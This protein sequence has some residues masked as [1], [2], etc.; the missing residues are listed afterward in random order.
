MAATDPAFADAQVILGRV[1]QLA[2][3]TTDAAAL[4]AAAGDRPDAK[5][6]LATLAFEAGRFTDALATFQK[7]PGDDAAVWTG[8]TLVRLGRFA[9]A[10]A[11]LEPLRS[12]TDHLPDQIARWLGEAQL[13][14][15]RTA[16]GL[17]SLRSA[18]ELVGKVPEH[19]DP[20]VRER[21]HDIRFAPGR[22]AAANRTAGRGRRPVPPGLG[23][24]RPVEA[25]GRV[26]GPDGDRVPASRQA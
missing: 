4:F 7:L 24:G 19:L 3:D 10:L 14:L 13:G 5:F 9:E 26:A 20:A 8:A 15:G 18:A 2:G 1:R 23:R 17:A 16:D 25:A 12:K 22:C 11:V 21:R 6:Q